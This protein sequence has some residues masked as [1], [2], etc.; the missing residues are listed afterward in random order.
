MQTAYFHMFIEN[1]GAIEEKE[2][3][4]NLDYAD[5]E[6]QIQGKIHEKVPIRCFAENAKILSYQGQK[7][8]LW[9]HFCVPLLPRK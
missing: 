6:A 2:F 7:I 9:G 1:V 4:E 3:R 5:E 8:F